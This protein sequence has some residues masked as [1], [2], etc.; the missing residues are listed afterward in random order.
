ML[1]DN[2]KLIKLKQNRGPGFAR[3]VGLKNITSGYVGFID[4]DDELILEDYLKL[5]SIIEVSK[6]DLCTFNGYFKN[7]DTIES[8]YDFHRLSNNTSDI[9]R[10][11][12]R[13]ELDGSVIFTIY[14][15]E[16]I[17]NFSL[18]FPDQYYEDIG[19][20]YKALLAGKK[21][22]IFDGYCYL[23]NN[24]Y[25]SIVNTIS[26][27]HI[28]GMLDACL[29]VKKSVQILGLS[30]Y[31]NFENDFNYGFNGYLAHLVIDILTKLSDR[32][33]QISLFEYLNSRVYNNPN[34][35]GLPSKLETAK[36][37][38]TTFYMQNCLNRNINPRVR[39]EKL[40]SYYNKSFLG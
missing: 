17:N 38:L 4:S 33:R 3:N 8:R 13:G 35:I 16:L 22:Q 29:S 24:R 21:R 32:N 15:I 37:R 40:V 5:I 7:H 1:S 6:P 14:S 9:T 12:L 10:I 34:F 36:D 20:A 19:F 23:K 39:F 26:M 11:C 30:D 25:G 31:K 28:D 27:S 18:T 2:I